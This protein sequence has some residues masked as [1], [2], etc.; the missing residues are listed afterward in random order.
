MSIYV[1]PRVPGA[2]IFFTV[3]LANKGSGLLTDQIGLLRTTVWQTR[4]ERPFHIDAWVV[5]PDHLHAVWTLPRGDTDFSTRWGAIKA[6]FT[7]GVRKAGFSPPPD[8]PVV[9]SGRYAG[10]KPGLRSE[11]REA[12]VWQRRFWEHHIRGPDEYLAAVSFCHNDPV[13]HGLVTDAKAWPFSTVH[14]KMQTSGE[15][16]RAGFSPP[17]VVGPG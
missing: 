3:T 12:G 4:R 16:C 10:L 9:R 1:R 14:R 13:K 15:M 7:M 6:R 2:T 17:S 11:K 8:L 5:L